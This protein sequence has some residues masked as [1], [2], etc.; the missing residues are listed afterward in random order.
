MSPLTH[1]DADAAAF[2]PSPASG[3]PP[4]AEPEAVALEAPSDVVARYLEATA[5]R[6]A[7]DDQ[8]AWLRAELELVA[9]QLLSEAR[10]RGRFVAP[11][12]AGFVLARLQPTCVF[13]RQTVAGELQRAGRLSDVAVLQGPALARFLAR[14]PVV[15]ARL[16]DLVRPR[17]NV[18]LMAGS[19]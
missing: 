17:R 14:E 1:P 4:V 6:R 18:V 10:P 19:A 5:Q 9:A 3:P 15:A 8:L 13:D 11:G 2:S 16:G 12:G 7:L